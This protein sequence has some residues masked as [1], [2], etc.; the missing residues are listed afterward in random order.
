MKSILIVEDDKWLA[1]QYVRLLNKAGYSA[2]FALNAYDAIAMVD[3]NIPDLIVLDVL[4]TGTTAFA[5]LNELQSYSDTGSIPIILC[6]TLA[7]DL[8]LENL[9]P[10][11]V[12]QI[13]D[14][15]IMVPE[16]LITALRR[17]LS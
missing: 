14:K 15:T 7:S 17:A 13:L 3:D 2:N 6:T 10:Y 16:D 1:Q 9:M 5:F 12:K 8:S 4:L 11:G